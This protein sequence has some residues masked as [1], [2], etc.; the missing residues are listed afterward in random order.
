V[1][2]VAA[3]VSLELAV[4]LVLKPNVLPFHEPTTAAMEQ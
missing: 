4:A 3:I 2:L 1:E